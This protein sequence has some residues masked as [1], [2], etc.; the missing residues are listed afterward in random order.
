MERAERKGTKHTKD[1]ETK[2]KGEQYFDGTN[3]NTC[4]IIFIGI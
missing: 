4:I 1:V 2:L 3:L